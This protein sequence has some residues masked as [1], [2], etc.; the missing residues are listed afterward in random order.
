MKKSQN[1]AVSPLPFDA[2]KAD[3]LECGACLA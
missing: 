3:L 2:D 1:L